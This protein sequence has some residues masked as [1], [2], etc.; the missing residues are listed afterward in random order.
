MFVERYKRVKARSSENE[1]GR[2]EYLLL[3]VRQSIYFLAVGMQCVVVA[4]PL[5]L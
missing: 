3:N 4:L 5:I 2:I 1:R